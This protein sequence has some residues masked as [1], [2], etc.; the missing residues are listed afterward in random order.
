MN[1][2]MFLPRDLGGQAASQ[3]EVDEIVGPQVEADPLAETADKIRNYYIRERTVRDGRAFRP[4]PSC[5][6]GVSR[7]GRRYK[8]IWPKVAKT[9]ADLDADPEQFVKAQF[10]ATVDVVYPNALVAA[11]AKQRWNQWERIRHGIAEAALKSEARALSWNLYRRRMVLPNETDRGRYAALA[12][13]DDIAPTLRRAL[14]LKAGL[15]DL[16]RRLDQAAESRAA[17]DPELYKSA[18][19]N[20]LEQ[21]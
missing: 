5:D 6:G 3:D 13:L 18:Y 21:S 1:F 11:K 17:A 14:A 20:F 9:V 2:E 8:P 19:N 10:V 16:A 12:Q 4:G 7:S 15:T